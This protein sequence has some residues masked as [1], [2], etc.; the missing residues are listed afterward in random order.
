[1]HPPHPPESSALQHG[2][3][4]SSAGGGSSRAGTWKKAGC[5]S[6]EP[7]GT[8]RCARHQKQ[9]ARFCRR[10]RNWSELRFPRSLGCS[11]APA[12]RRLSVGCHGHTSGRKRLSAPFPPASC[13]PSPEPA[14]QHSRPGCCEYVSDLPSRDRRRNAVTESRSAPEISALDFPQSFLSSVMLYQACP[15]PSQ[16]GHWITARQ[17]ESSR[18]QLLSREQKTLCLH[19]DGASE[20]EEARPICLMRSAGGP[21]HSFLDG[22]TVCATPQMS[23]PHMRA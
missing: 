21:S 3:Y 13:T 2:P 6:R 22:R 9:S 14:E 8:G 23:G 10:L 5:R 7:C 17:E 20:P 16:F 19:P 12:T 4:P 11:A 18:L 1:M 15:R